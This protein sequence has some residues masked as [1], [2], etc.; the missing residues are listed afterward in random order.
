LRGPL[1]E[2]GGKGAAP[3]RAAR[4]SGTRTCCALCLRVSRNGTDQEGPLRWRG[5]RM[6]RGGEGPG[7]WQRSRAR[8]LARRVECARS[9]GGQGLVPEESVMVIEE[10]T[11]SKRLV[12][13]RPA[14]DL[15]PLSPVCSGGVGGMDC[16]RPARAAEVQ[17][18]CCPPPG[19]H[20]HHHHWRPRP[21]GGI[22]ERAPKGDRSLRMRAAP[23]THRPGGPGE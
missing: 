18:R 20:H 4:W 17:Q 8:P 15:A 19:T 10:A 5:S 16:T 13:V 9:C 12:Q 22:V 3:P 14:P 2:E 11:N 6:G 23:S 7:R 21:L 1:R